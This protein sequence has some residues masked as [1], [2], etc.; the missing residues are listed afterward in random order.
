MVHTSEFKSVLIRSGSGISHAPPPPSL[1]SFL[2][3]FH[4]FNVF[5]Y[6]VAI[7]TVMTENSPAFFPAFPVFLY[8]VKRTTSKH[9]LSLDGDTAERKRLLN[10]GVQH[11]A[12]TRE[13]SDDEKEM[14]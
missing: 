10:Y 4:L 3:C 6:F 8:R 13:H 1:L 12:E 5:F 9:H 11:T 7:R 14:S 2:L